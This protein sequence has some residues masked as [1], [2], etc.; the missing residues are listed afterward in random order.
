MPSEENIFVVTL[1]PG[2]FKESDYDYE[3]PRDTYHYVELVSD[4]MPLRAL[5]CR[6]VV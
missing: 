2:Q 5:I 3:S 6:V 1:G 4:L